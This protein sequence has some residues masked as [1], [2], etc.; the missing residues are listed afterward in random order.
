M[1]RLCL[2]L[3][4]L[5]MVVWLVGEDQI[6]ASGTAVLG[7]TASPAAAAAPPAGTTAAQQPCCSQPG[8]T[9]PYQ[10]CINNQC[11][12][13]NDCGVSDCS[14]CLSCDPQAEQQCL[15][16]GGTWDSS[17]CVCTPPPPPPCDPTH[18][19]QSD[20]TLAGGVWDPINC[21]CTNTSLCVD[22]QDELVSSSVVTTT[23]CL[24]DYGDAQVCT[25]QIDDWQET[26]EG[27]GGRYVDNSWSEE[28]DSCYETYDS[29]CDYSL[30]D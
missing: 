29:S 6:H 15:S 14:A 8:E 24:D 11:V 12:W 16:E 19:K 4:L 28:T 26:C 5:V 2:L 7:P 20:C 17:S 23:I 30:L 25:T 3:G 27:P 22:P 18:V 13:I 1:R 10:T 9:Y 21:Q